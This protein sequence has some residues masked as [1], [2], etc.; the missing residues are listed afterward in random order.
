MPDNKGLNV[1]VK[2][3]IDDTGK[4]LDGLSSKVKEVN[5]I[6]KELATNLGKVEKSYKGLVDATKAYND[7]QEKANN[8]G[9]TASEKYKADLKAQ[10]DVMKAEIK[11]QTEVQKNADKL[12]EQAHQASLKVRRQNKEN[13][14]KQELQ[15]EQK[16][17]KEALAI[18]KAV[19]AQREKNIKAS[20]DKI[21]ALLKAHNDKQEALEK[22]AQKRL[23]DASKDIEKEK[24]SQF[25]KYQKDQLAYQKKIDDSKIK[26][27]KDSASVFK[28]IWNSETAEQKAEL[29]KQVTDYKQAQSQMKSGASVVAGVTNKNTS[30]GDSS[31]LKSSILSA[32]ISLVGIR[33]LAAAFSDLGT[34]IIEVNYNAI[35]TQRIMNDFSEQTT[36]R[37][38]DSAIAT[39]KGTGTQ[40]TDI[41]EIQSAWVRIND[42]Y[43]NSEAL[44]NRITDLTAKFMNVGEIEDAE[45]AVK[46]LNA[47]L[48]QFNDGTR[49][50][51]D[52]AEEVLNKW[53]YM[54]DKTAMGTADEFGASM[55]KIGGYM[56][57]LGGG[58]DDAIVMTSVLG[59]RLAKSGDEAGNSL[60]TINAYLT[61]QKT[62]TLFEDLGNDAN[63]MSYSLKDANGQFR[64]FTELMDRASRAYNDFKAAGD[65]ETAKKIQEAL[66]ATRQGD[67]AL[68]LLQNWSTDSAKYYAMV[69]DSVS[70]EMSYLDKQNAALMETFKAQWNSLYATIL[71]FGMA[72]ANSGVL[73]G[74]TN[75][76]DAV[77]SAFTS[78][79]ALNPEI[80]NFATTLGS[81]ALGLFAFKSIGD[82]TG[83]L[84]T[85]TTAVKYGTQAQRESATAIS[86]NADAYLKLAVS[87][88]KASKDNGEIAKLTNIKLQYNELA[89][90]YEKGAITATQYNTALT[91]LIGTTN[92]SSV[93]G[94]KAAVSQQVNNLLKQQGIVIEKEIILAKS[95]STRGTI[96]E[97]IA[98]VTSTVATRAST[99]ATKALNGAMQV[100]SMLK[101]V[102]LSPLTLVTLG[103]TALIKVYDVMT[104]SAEEQQ[105][106]ID[107]LSASYTKLNDELTTLVNKSSTST[108]SEQEKE[109]LAYLKERVGLEE[110]LLNVEKKK[111]ATQDINGDNDLMS[112]VKDAVAGPANFGGGSDKGL[113]SEI[114]DTTNSYKVL[115]TQI[116]ALN[117]E[118]EDLTYKRKNL[119]ANRD[120]LPN[121]ESPEWKALDDQIKSVTKSQ[122]EVSVKIKNGQ[123]QYSALQT[124]MID[125]MAKIKEYTEIGAFTDTQKQEFSELYNQLD[126]IS[127]KVEETSESFKS[128]QDIEVGINI[129]EFTT[130]INSMQDGLAS[131]DADI[132]K[133]EGGT[134][135]S[136]DLIGMMN[137]YAGSDFYSV[138]NKGADK[139]LELLRKI[140]T[141]KLE[142]Q[143]ASI[144]E[145]QN[146]LL[147]QR[148]Q[149]LERIASMG[150]TADGSP[151]DDAT[152]SQ[153]SEKLERI[154]K[155]L[156]M[157]TATRSIT[158]FV[159]TTTIEDAVNSMGELV[160]S[161]LELVRAQEQLATGTALSS[162]QMFNLTQ[163]Y[164]E[165]LSYADLFNTTSVQGQ[166]DAINAVLDMKEQEYDAKIDIQINELVAEK[167][168]IEEQ[169]SLEQTKIEALDAIELA[170][171]SSQLDYK[172]QLLEGIQSYNE[173][174]GQDQVVLE[175]GIL[176]VKEDALNKQI[177]GE[178]EAGVQNAKIQN[179]VKDNI[180]AAWEIGGSNAIKAARAMLDRCNELFNSFKEGGIK[181]LAQSIGDMLSGKFDA[182]TAITSD[183]SGNDTLT[184]SSQQ[185]TF[186]VNGQAD[187]G[188]KSV[189]DWVSSQRDTVNKTISASNLR[190]EKIM[191]SIG[192]LEKLKEMSI[193]DIV[194]KFKPSKENGGTEKSEIEKSMEAATKAAEE[195]AKSADDAANAAAKAAKEAADAIAKVTE[196]YT[197]NVESLQDRIVK[198]LKAK[199]EEQY[200]ERKKLLE[201]EQDTQVAFHNDRIQ[202]LQDEID[203]LNGNTKED[204]TAKLTTLESELNEWKKDDSS[205]GK[206]KQKELTDKI[207]DL[208]KEMSIDDLESQIE[209]EQDKVTEINNHFKDLFNADSPLY[210]PTLKDID[211]R[212]TYQSLYNEANEMIKQE[213][214]Q[215][216]IDLLL[217]YD[218]DYAGIAQLMGMT[219]GQ[220]IALEVAK[221]IN[222][223]LDL[224]DGTIQAVGG[225]TSGGD[226]GSGGSGGS[227]NGTD[228]SGNRYHDVV[229]GDPWGDTLWDL[230]EQYY[231][232]GS[233][234]EKIYNANTDQIDDPSTIYPGQ[235][236][237]IPFKIG[238]YT[239]DQEG[240]AYLHKKERVLTAQQTAAFDSLVYNAMPKLDNKL[241]NTNVGD[242]NNNKSINY[243]G[244]LVK[245]EVGQITNNTPFDVKNTE[246]NLN[247]LI[248]NT[249]QKSGTKIN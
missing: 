56:K 18:Q 240:A 38:T 154:N 20:R 85:F 36:Q 49:D 6:S 136:K 247:R 186:D 23:Q 149:L 229:G 165:L 157:L 197:K 224:R 119:V 190:I 143:E 100:G 62:V 97:T 135:S 96:A 2:F 65:D 246:D 170:G 81:V 160:N 16:S 223:Y 200:E 94:E 208:N 44:L 177:D 207:A 239:G 91:K 185:I 82:M 159:D 76:M 225:D 212:L 162:E 84:T 69:E 161:T 54:A 50:N 64:N 73:E 205:L 1:G 196:E 34:N 145:K 114:W 113:K 68:S 129:E 139:Q 126:T 123:D 87:E 105:A 12:K 245:I 99:V 30:F 98:T 180:I 236:L 211:K 138:A 7:A 238:G 78:I 232:D 142:D 125:Y 168:V 75:I 228:S 167:T 86:K 175:D 181:G 63:G 127:K 88:A 220:I 130:T 152:L 146:Q 141:Q 183:F 26:S 201:K 33:A 51:G 21:A 83:F 193:T 158:L 202:Q 92:L 172:K 45:E 5:K 8:S 24:S 206:S 79:A 182:T 47:T 221:A 189:N 169:L 199:Y 103:I 203:K 178:E 102:L 187:I 230:A 89:K 198:A 122:D 52:L 59:D 120:S 237:L 164:P 14:A 9:M 109:R 155:D 31:S 107:E 174:Q 137:T 60:K 27:A 111:Q 195:A 235:R 29:N 58:I 115:E 166:Q 242:T 118:Y 42:E 179:S 17:A 104:V 35:N 19:E 222:N 248:T 90:I 55:A 173:A 243:N 95:L 156:D 128:L 70:G 108:L 226:T 150:Y 241:L 216:I 117:S 184:Q 22:A 213:K 11:A 43:S 10:T 151:I 144:D 101:D 41:Q 112:F 39:A 244:E 204:K 15:T 3:N 80:L 32:G 28:S 71:G 61:R 147:E 234:W 191:F 93:A 57:S 53:A 215:E 116:A 77:D 214:T 133:I 25:E 249:L 4:S 171:A 74:M 209:T 140:K 48:L 67:V 131:I 121:K 233:Q 66:G 110:D 72:I 219:A 188:G 46:L 218:P 217:A 210:D 231:G 106:K 192:N 153:A 134:A 13:A 37:L 40:V 163:Q 148:S 227:S 194:A 132:E 124:K 176:K